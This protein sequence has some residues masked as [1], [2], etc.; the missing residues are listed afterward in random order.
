MP[1]V[2]LWFYCPTQ[3]A[4]G[5]FVTKGSLFCSEFISKTVLATATSI[6]FLLT[7]IYRLCNAF[8]LQSIASW[9]EIN[10]PAAY[11]LKPINVLQNI[12]KFF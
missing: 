2:N 11:K 1:F 7:Y 9:Y 4:E 5:L 12:S 10:F 8:A 3:V 6:S